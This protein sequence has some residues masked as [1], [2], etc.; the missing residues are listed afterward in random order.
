MDVA[1][2]L[3]E[4]LAAVGIPS[5]QDWEWSTI[6]SVIAIAKPAASP[7]A[8]SV[9]GG[10]AG[11]EL[12]TR[13]ISSGQTLTQDRFVTALTARGWQVLGSGETGEPAGSAWTEAGSGPAAAMKTRGC[14]RWTS[15]KAR[16]AG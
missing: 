13:L 6:P 5:T 10:D 1:Q 9:Q 4:K 15:Q 16:A 7:L 3:A 8:D 14:I 12:S 2:H 11:D